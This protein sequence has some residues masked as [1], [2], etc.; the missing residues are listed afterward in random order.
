[1]GQSFAKGREATRDRRAKLASARRDKRS[2]RNSSGRA[3]SEAS[4]PRSR[5]RE[6]GPAATADPAEKTDDDR[7]RRA[8]CQAFYAAKCRPGFKDVTDCTAEELLA[9]GDGL[10]SVLL[11]DCRA[12]KEIA[13]SK[14]AGSVTQREFDVG[15]ERMLAEGKTEVVMYCTI[16]G[17]SGAA[18]KAFGAKHPEVKIANLAGSLIEWAHAGGAVVDAEGLPTT[19]IHAWGRKFAAMMPASIDAVV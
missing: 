14:L 12:D 17:R 2:T 1:M 10:A 8:A 5:V 3:V 18:A 6:D 4:Q 7:M 9:R 11:V 16:G 15:W 19:R 13:I